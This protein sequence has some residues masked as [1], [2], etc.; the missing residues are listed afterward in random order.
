MYDSS[1]NKIAV[2]LVAQNPTYRN[3][4]SRSKLPYYY[5]AN[6]YLGKRLKDDSSAFDLKCLCGYSEISFNE[7]E[8]ALNALKEDFFF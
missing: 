2:F 8:T 7:Y 1:L 4:Y 3:P 6:C 5:N